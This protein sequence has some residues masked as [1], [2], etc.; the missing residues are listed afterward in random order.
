[1]HIECISEGKQVKLKRH[2]SWVDT[3]LNHKNVKC[4]YVTMQ[5]DFEIRKFAHAR[6]AAICDQFTTRKKKV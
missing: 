4:N 1:M 3:N 5:I 2:K 6:E